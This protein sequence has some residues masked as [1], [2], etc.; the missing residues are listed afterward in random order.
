M[1]MEFWAMQYAGHVTVTAP[2]KLKERIRNRLA[3][4]VENYGVVQEKHNV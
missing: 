2:V 1:A 4:A 3:E